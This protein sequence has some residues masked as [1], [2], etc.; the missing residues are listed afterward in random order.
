M[1]SAD[2][3]TAWGVSLWQATARL[4]DARPVLTG[5]WRADLAIVGGGFTGLSA[6]LHAAL[7]GRSVVLVEARTLA[8]GAS[9]RNAGFVVPNFARV[10][11][12]AVIARLGE[13]RG[14]RLIAFAAESADTV[15][16]LISRHGI[17]CDAR[18]D[19]W[20][21]PARGEAAFARVKA[22]A[23][24]WA[25]RGR[26][27]AVLDREAVAAATGVRGYA[28]G[29]IDRSGGVL[30]P[31]DYAQGLARAAAAA[32]ARLFEQ[33]SVTGITRADGRWRVATAAGVVDADRVVVAT[34]AHGGG[35]HRDLARSY[36]PLRV[37]QVATRPVGTAVR[38]R[39]LAGGACV[40][41][42]R[43]NLFTFRFDAADRLISGGMAVFEPG[44]ETRVAR[45][46]H[47]RLARVLEIGDLPPLAFAWSG[48][49][50]VMPDFLPRLIE[51][52]PGMVA[53]I[54]CNG[55]GIAMTT[56][57]GR[58]LADWAAGMDDLPVPLS[59]AAPLPF[60]PVSRHAPNLLLP[61]S[62]LRDA[63]EDRG[64]GP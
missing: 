32:G 64:P 36:F 12:D 16:R 5:A 44:A 9:G 39:L 8:W 3:G 31:V 4:A 58:V 26:P 34:N 24:Q 38:R 53:G 15:F 63:L 46:I 57:L 6:A 54:A 19:G 43:R 60:H 37:F 22:R 2:A 27:V 21:Q 59:P 48:V 10:D 17:A 35:L 56:M 41:D 30:H 47:R 61:L 62:L 25:R 13:T 50:A 14:E 29:W 55:R 18:R 42:S 40:S 52:G 11:P 20:I 1:K 28:G 33:S 7:A 49:A 51:L 23:A 45:A